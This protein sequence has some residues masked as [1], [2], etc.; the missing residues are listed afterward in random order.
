MEPYESYC[1]E[2]KIIEMYKLIKNNPSITEERLADIF[3]IAGKTVRNYKDKLDEVWGVGIEYD[4]KGKKYSVYNDGKLAT[5][6]IST[7]LSADDVNLIIFTLINARAFMPVK[8]EIIQNALLNML[9]QEEIENLKTILPSI[10]ESQRK[11]VN[12]EEI[13][14]SQIRK[15]MIDKR[16]ISF[17]YLASGAEFPK[18]HKAIPYSFACDHGKYYVISKPESKD[19]LI[20]FRLDRMKD[21]IILDEPGERPDEFEVMNYLKRTWYMYGGD[22]IKVTV[23][24]KEGCRQVVIERNMQE[25]SIVKEGDGYFDYEFITNGT[26]GI[27]IWLLGFGSSAEVL[28]PERLREEMREIA[29]GMVEVYEKGSN[30]A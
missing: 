11:L 2:R 30:Q 9:P 26:D 3:K 21:I 27:K 6:K 1:A 12:Q 8:M 14:L 4:K 20:H 25:G 15:G 19:K 13:N 23:R 24:F 18:F 5:L 22:E 28:E 10:T 17:M 16:K 29:E 7:P